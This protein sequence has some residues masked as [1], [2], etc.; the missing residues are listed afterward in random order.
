MRVRAD[1]RVGKRAR[2]SVRLLSEN[3]GREVF[4][5]DLVNDACSRRDDLEVAKRLLSPF[6]ELVALAVAHKLDFGVELERLSVT[7][8]VD[9]Y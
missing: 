8:A 2:G 6:E 9:L 5:I 7:G 3:N 1:Q 4:Q